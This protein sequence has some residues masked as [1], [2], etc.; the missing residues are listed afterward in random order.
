MKAR[1]GAG[2]NAVAQDSAMVRLV[3]ADLSIFLGP[4]L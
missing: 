3:S 2:P 4:A 1:L